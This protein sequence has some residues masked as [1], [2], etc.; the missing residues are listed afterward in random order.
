MVPYLRRVNE[1]P[2]KYGEGLN[3]TITSEAGTKNRHSLGGSSEPRAARA[4]STD[5]PLAR[6]LQGESAPS[7][8]TVW[9]I[10]FGAWT[11]FAAF[12]AAGSYSYSIVAAGPA[13]AWKLLL[14]WNF[15]DAYTWALF[16]PFIFLL[17]ER[18]SFNQGNW[19]IPFL[20]Q[21]CFA[22]LFASTGALITTLFNFLLPWTR[23]HPFAPFRVE[24]FTLFLGD[25]PRY[26]LI[27][28]VSQAIS[29]RNQYRQRELKSSRLEMQLTHA[30]LNALKM[31]IEPHFLFNV[32]NSIATLTRRDA[33]AA[34]RMT[35]QLADLLRMSLQN[36]GRHEVPLRQELEFLECYLRIQQ[37][38]FQDRLAVRFDID[39]LA[40]DA[41]VPH[42]VLQPLVEN[43]VR[44]GIAPRLS[45]GWIEVIARKL[46]EQLVVEVVDN[47]VGLPPGFCE[48]STHGV[49]LSNTRARLRQLHGD[50][51]AFHCENRIDG[52]CEIRIFLPFRETEGSRDAR[53]HTNADCGR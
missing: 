41:V 28:A 23:S 6:S 2:A 22:V 5:P 20:L 18:I 12:G 7:R 50:N 9:I 34:E 17:S 45:P 8:S 30:Q 39:P 14:T 42:L 53:E 13:P 1:T 3:G 11:V 27:V 26:C 25:I 44:H 36:V 19:R 29:Y 15:S 38:R 46:E 33:A 21:T 10:S 31:Q 16:T 4:L 24:L 47:G 37:T 35:L 43:S 32:L 49:G 51:F 48:N 52:G 40:L